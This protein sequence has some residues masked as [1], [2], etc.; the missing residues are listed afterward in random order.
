MRSK[1]RTDMSTKQCAYD[2]FASADEILEVPS[3][4]EEPIPSSCRAKKESEELKE[5]LPTSSAQ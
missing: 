2:E 3:S 5:K 4:S 1:E